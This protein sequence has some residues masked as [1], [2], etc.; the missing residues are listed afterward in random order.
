[1]FVLIFLVVIIVALGMV[2]IS[3]VLPESPRTALAGAWYTSLLAVLTILVG[4]LS[5]G[6]VL[7]M[8]AFIE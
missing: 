8:F 2:G 1:M 7:L 5:I 6:F 3:T 4:L